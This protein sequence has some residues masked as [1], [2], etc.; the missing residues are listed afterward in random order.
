MYTL[1][2]LRWLHLELLQLYTCFP[3]LLW[4]FFDTFLLP[5]NGHFTVVILVTIIITRFLYNYYIGCKLKYF[6]TLPFL[7]ENPTKTLHGLISE[8]G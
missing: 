3:V 8:I 2:K 6:R 5:Q 4:P 1:T 7:F